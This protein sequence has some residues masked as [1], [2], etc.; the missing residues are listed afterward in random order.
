VILHDGREPLAPGGHLLRDG[1]DGK[2][3]WLARTVERA[4]GRVNTSPPIASGGM[5]RDDSPTHRR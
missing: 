1:L 2:L 3:E 5:A 4:R